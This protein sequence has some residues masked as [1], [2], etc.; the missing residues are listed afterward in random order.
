MLMLFVL[1]LGLVY[2]E[3]LGIPFAAPPVDELRWQPPQS[4]TPWDGILNATSYSIHCTQLI[5]PLYVFIGMGGISGEDC[6]YLNIWVPKGVEA[7]E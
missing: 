6:L 5:A 1:Y 7:N 3:Y 2:E 4:V